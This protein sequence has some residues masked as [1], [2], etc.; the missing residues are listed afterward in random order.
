M[1]RSQIVY[2]DL[3]HT[4]LNIY[5][6]FVIRA[7]KHDVLVI[8]TEKKKRSE[9]R[10]FRD[11]Q[12]LHLLLG[13]CLTNGF[14]VV[15]VDFVF[16]QFRT[17]DLGVDAE[18]LG[19]GCDIDL[20]VWNNRSAGDFFLEEIVCDD[21]LRFF[22]SFQFV[23]AKFFGL[24]GVKRD[25]IFFFVGGDEFGLGL[26]PSLEGLLVIEDAKVVEVCESGHGVVSVA[27]ME[28]T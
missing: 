3:T 27:S 5:I 17:S 7:R 8:I 15:S 19:D 24:V 16:A 2:Y 18:F 21:L 10:L 1:Y 6:K 20:V 4:L 26:F 28:T 12:E 11:V 9:E 14:D 25:R 23:A 22:V 13:E